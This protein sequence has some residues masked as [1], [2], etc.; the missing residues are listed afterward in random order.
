MKPSTSRRK[1]RSIVRKTLFRV[2]TSIMSF[3]SPVPVVCSLRLACRRRIAQWLPRIF[4]LT[5][6][7][8]RYTSQDDISPRV[9]H[10]P[11]PLT[12][13]SLTSVNRFLNE[14]KYRN[15]AHSHPS[16]ESRPSTRC[17]PS[18]LSYSRSSVMRIRDFPGGHAYQATWGE[19]FQ[20]TNSSPECSPQPSRPAEAYIRFTNAY[21]MAAAG[22]LIH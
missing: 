5:R 8:F 17:P 11:P 20:R 3:H 9:C 10:N 4:P 12:S 21:Y 2:H 15:S 18:D 7:R 6:P 1:C 16:S 14:T 19:N 13:V 22:V